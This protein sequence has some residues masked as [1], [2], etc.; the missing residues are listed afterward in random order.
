[1]AL[2]HHI[3]CHPPFSLWSLK[4]AFT[5]ALTMTAPLRAYADQ[6][7]LIGVPTTLF[8][9]AMA[10]LTSASLTVRSVSSCPV[11]LSAPLIM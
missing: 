5:L 4:L 3:H 11:C 10:L 7:L 1:M 8:F 2:D 6:A 9:G